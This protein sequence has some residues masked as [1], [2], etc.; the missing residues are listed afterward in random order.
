ML[1][2]TAI[3]QDRMAMRNSVGSGYPFYLGDYSS[4]SFFNHV[5]PGTVL[6]TIIT[7]LVKKIALRFLNLLISGSPI[8]GLLYD[9]DLAF[10]AP[11]RFRSR[12]TKSRALHHIDV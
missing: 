10:G 11:Q 5:V 3:G 6:A 7:V 9:L 2:R 8:K 12:V 1:S 4:Y